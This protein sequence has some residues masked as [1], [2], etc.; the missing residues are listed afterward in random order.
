M[1][2]T[3]TADTTVLIAPWWRIPEVTLDYRAA[4]S[5]QVDAMAEEVGVTR[6]VTL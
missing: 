3:E 2:M 4:R 6:R 1:K 5:V